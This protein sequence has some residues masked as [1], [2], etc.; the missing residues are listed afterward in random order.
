VYDVHIH[1]VKRATKDSYHHGDLRNALIEAATQ[2]VRDVGADS[3]SLRDAAGTVGVSPNA[4]YRHFESKADL[5]TAVAVGGFEKLAQRMRR[6]M[7]DAIREHATDGPAEVAIESFKACGRAYVAFAD[8]FPELF[9]VMYG[10]NGLCR[11]GRTALPEGSPPP[12]LILGESLDALMN[13]GVLPA[14]RRTGAEL[15]AWC[16]VHGLVSLPLGGTQFPTAARRAEAL[17]G[18][19]DFA[20]DG[21]CHERHPGERASKSAPMKASARRRPRLRS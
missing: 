11:F 8:E 19:L 10:P 5:L 20:L 2:L 17:E 12:L 18:L 9:R 13:A 4:M 3:F 21:L 14:E 6:R 7:S 15:R 1:D 16:V